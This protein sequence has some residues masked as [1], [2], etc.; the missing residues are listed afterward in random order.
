MAR[1]NFLIIVADDLG[2]S[3]I[4]C[5]GGEIKTPNLDKLGAAG[6]RFTGFHTASACSPTRAM[7]MSG[8]DHHLAGVGQM[9][10]FMT[11]GSKAQ[12]AYWKDK[13]GYEGELNRKVAALPELMK[14]AGYFT[15][16]SGKW[17]LGLTKAT[18]PCSRGFDR[19]FSMLHGGH[20]H[21]AFEPQVQPSDASDVDEG[22]GSPLRNP[23]KPPL[24][25]E[26]DQ[27]I[28]ASSL[29]AD[30][31]STETFTDR[32][33][34]YLEGRSP[35]EK[36][37]PFFAYLP[38]TA[39][40]FPLQAPDRLI[41]KYKGRYDAGPEVLRVERIE[42]LKRLGLIP[43]NVHPHP[44]VPHFKTK[45]WVDLA[46]D[47]RKKS[48]KMME[49]YAAMVESI[50]ENVGKVV[51]YLK[52]TGE[53]E[54]TFIMFISD[55]GAEGGLLE[56]RPM[57]GER[58]QNA[59]KKY[60]DN[61]LE[62]IG[63]GNSY[64]YYGPRWAQAATAP[65][66][67]YKTWITEGGIRTPCIVHYPKYKQANITHAMTTCLDLLPTMLELAGAT[68][69]SETG[70]GV[71]RGRK[72]L[73]V[74]GKSWVPLLSGAAS[75]VYPDDYAICWELFGQQAIRKGDYKAIFIPK[76]MGSGKWELYNVAADAGEVTNI[77]AKEPLRLESMITEWSAYALNSNVVE[78]PPSPLGG[79]SKKGKGG[80]AGAKL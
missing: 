12:Q 14:D 30:F 5:F 33:V 10:E 67:L 55:N 47:E 37:A 53:F 57:F 19:N 29:P 77:A 54:N 59:I 27:F 52:T 38:Y 13:E 18:A 76:P 20:N 62:N 25:M 51:E 72:V 44:M 66:R 34:E 69:P 61:S 8:T 71:F 22:P 3:D 46:E 4:G 26:G 74:R 35:T 40:H 17:H 50:D 28:P 15:L 7:L 70:N 39:P 16:M 58:V 6:T 75:E 9:V 43:Q 49:V 1:P 42:H 79:G 73:P 63:R 2:F 23:G 32:L 80:A 21:Y 45:N 41:A 48:A 78:M 64:V 60:Y 65:S 56:A 68:H 36:Q 24:Y 11:A 31:Y